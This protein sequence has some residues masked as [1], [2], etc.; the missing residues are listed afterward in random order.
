MQG[1][2]E[3]ALILL[4]TNG[5]MFFK[6]TAVN[7]LSKRHYGIRNLSRIPLCF[8]WK[9][10][11]VDAEVL[12]VEPV[13]GVIEP[14]EKMFHRWYFRP[15]MADKKY[16]MRPTLLAWGKGQNT[17]SS[18]G[19]CQQFIVRSIGEGVTAEIR[20]EV[21]YV[22]YG[23]IMVGSTISKELVLLNDGQCSL[24][25]KLHVEQSID[26][27]FN[28]SQFNTDPVGL[29]LEWQYGV[30]AAR[31]KC[32][33]GC[34][35][36]PVRRLFYKWT[37]HYQLLKPEDSE[38]LSLSI[39]V[40][41]W[42][43]KGLSKKQLWDLFSLDDHLENA[44]S[45]TRAI[46]DFNFSSAPVDSEPSYV[47]LLLEN[48]GSIICE[49][50]FLFPNDVQEDLEYWAETGDLDDQELHEMKVQDNKLFVIEPK[51]GKLQ[52]GENQVIKFTYKHIM[53][54][55]DRLP[56]L[57]KVA[58][59]REILLNFIGVTVER[60]RRYI[61]FNSDQFMFSPVPIGQKNC[62]VQVYELFNG[63][64]MPVKY[65][66]GLAQ[67]EYL[68]QVDVPIRIHNAD[69]A[70]ITFT[71]AGYDQRAM[72]ET[73]PFNDRIGDSNVPLQ[74]LIHPT[75]QLCYLSKER[76][77]LGNIPLFSQC[78]YLVALVNRSAGQTAAF[79]WYITSKKDQKVVSKTEQETY[80]EQMAAWEKEQERQIVEFTITEDDINADQR[81]AVVEEPSAAQ[82]L[83]TPSSTTQ[84]QQ[85]TMEVQSQP[86]MPSSRLRAVSTDGIDASVT[87]GADL[88]SSK[89]KPDMDERPPSVKSLKS[90][91]VSRTPSPEI[92]RYK[93]LPPIKQQSVDDVRQKKKQASKMLKSFWPTPQPPKPFL[94]HLGVTARTHDISEFQQNFQDE[95]D[96]FFIDRLL[97]ESTEEVGNANIER[98][99]EKIACLKSE[100][101]IVA[102]V[103]TDVIRGLLE[104]TS[105]HT[106]CGRVF[107]EPIPYFQQYSDKGP[108]K[109]LQSAATSDTSFS[110]NLLSPK[111]SILSLAG[112]M[113]PFEEDPT[114][115]SVDLPPTTADT[116]ASAKSSS[117]HPRPME[118]A[119][120]S[121]KSAT[122]G[123]SSRA[124]STRP[125]GMKTDDIITRS[126]EVEREFSEKQAIK[127]M[128]EFGNFTESLLENTL[129][130]IMQEAFSE[131]FQITA[132]PRLVALPPRSSST[133]SLSRRAT[134]S[135]KPSSI[136]EDPVPISKSEKGS[137]SEK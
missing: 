112:T 52:P 66:F 17:T 83:N 98:D 128:S 80:V 29:Q 130:N 43:T 1:S 131:E 48:T 58:R 53:A 45:E 94:L 23:P 40:T 82:T 38:A 25:Y 95:Y 33:I 74:Q 101:E 7:S 126:Y 132:R 115:P 47:E 123:Q 136:K 102:D 5:E 3:E 13:T 28:S 64:A 46:L 113:A 129:T 39:L 107:T 68:N 16:V 104:D 96:H 42:T 79:K 59:G 119:R 24:H 87:S 137:P 32:S 34:L 20:A 26:N 55:T 61:H 77:S 121:E 133:K 135:V 97:S 27:T 71:G 54:G 73:M 15:K 117:S 6:P 67:L 92:S 4:D 81:V 93:T 120:S 70:V 22:D 100:S 56:V 127:K 134:P 106:A 41:G 63:G 21:P 111:G 49:W 51:K 124:A 108:T 62:P 110:V 118:L 44:I 18:G 99:D 78:R 88:L 57:F 103:L 31:S 125:S 69:T 50:S 12:S 90:L 37:V 8:E 91:E 2:A 60:D 72:G 85:S 114:S 75:G 116:Q 10:H 109:R 105:F 30:L 11:A 14:N 89:W 76:I 35:V 19:K 86:F 122:V 36:R 84:P 65:S 9:M